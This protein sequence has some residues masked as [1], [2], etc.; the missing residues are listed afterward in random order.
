MKFLLRSPEVQ[1]AL[2]NIARSHIEGVT[3]KAGIAAAVALAATTNAWA[4][5]DYRCTIENT[6]AAKKSR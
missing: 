5:E 4:A 2:G 1:V 6:V 3:M